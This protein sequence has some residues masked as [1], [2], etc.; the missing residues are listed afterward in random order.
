M[1]FF[2]LPYNN[3]P[4]GPLATGFH[5]TM[6][7]RRPMHVLAD[8]WTKTGPTARVVIRDLMSLSTDR[9]FAIKPELRPLIELRKS[10]LKERDAAEAEEDR[11]AEMEE[12]NRCVRLPKNMLV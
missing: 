5:S 8:A 3:K 11:L 10:D 7:D 9:R 2:P 1:P 12:Q 4:H 6:A